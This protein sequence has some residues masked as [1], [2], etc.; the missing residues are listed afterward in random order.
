M[1]TVISFLLQTYYYNF[2]KKDVD[3]PHLEIS[4][5]FIVVVITTDI[6]ADDKQS[7]PTMVFFSLQAF[8]QH[9]LPQATGLS[10]VHHQ[11]WQTGNH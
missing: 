4:V 6:H 9:T 8:P 1:V 2:V 7:I 5:T 11:T 10:T 3:H